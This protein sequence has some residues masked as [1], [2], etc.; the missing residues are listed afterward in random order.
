MVAIETR[1]QA[2]VSSK[3]VDLIE[4]REEILQALLKL[5]CI[6]AGMYPIPAAAAPVAAGGRSR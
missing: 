4:D 1:Y 3:R 5:D 2:F 6:P